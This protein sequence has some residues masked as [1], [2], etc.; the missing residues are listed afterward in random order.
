MIDR[1]GRI[2]TTI[3]HPR[4]RKGAYFP[5]FVVAWKEETGIGK[6]IVIT[7]NDIKNLIMS[8]AS[9][10]AACITLM[11]E[12]GIT[13]AAISARSTSRAASATTSTRRTR[14]PSA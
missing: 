11:N 12:A 4:I 2:N 10:L 9:V 13:Q 14:S 3:D 5:E 7:E 6:D 1:T 8:K